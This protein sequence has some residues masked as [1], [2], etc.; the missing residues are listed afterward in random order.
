[1][2]D[3]VTGGTAPTAQEYREAAE[4]AELH[5]EDPALARLLTH[6]AAL[7]AQFSI[8]R[9]DDKAAVEQIAALRADLT[10]CQHALAEA[11]RKRDEALRKVPEMP[12]LD[13][14]DGPEGYVRVCHNCHDHLIDRCQRA[15]SD[16]EALRAEVARMTEENADLAKMLDEVGQ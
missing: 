14:C 8:N 6:A 10:A 13:D 4:H 16:R 7:Q 15:E 2:S 11:E 1:M 3:A 12:C 5:A 9:I